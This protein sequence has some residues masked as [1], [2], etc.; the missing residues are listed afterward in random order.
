MSPH[1]LGARR[2]NPDGKKQKILRRVYKNPITGPR[3]FHRTR[4]GRLPPEIREKIFIELLADPPSYAG[5][6][7]L[8]PEPTKSRAAAK[9]FVHIKESWYHVTQTCR[10]IYLESQPIFFAAKAYYLE[11][12]QDLARFLDP[13]NLR[14][15][16]CDTITALCL[17]DLMKEELCFT[18]EQVDDLLTRMNEQLNSDRRPYWESMTRKTFDHEACN[19]VKQ[20]KNLRKVGLCMRV[21]EEMLYLNLIYFLSGMRKGLVEFIDA[22]RW[23]I[24]PQSPEDPWSIQYACFGHGSFL[25]KDDQIIP[26]DRVCIEKEV[27]DIDSRAPGLQE[28]DE[29]YIEAEIQ[30]PVVKKSLKRPVNPYISNIDWDTRSTGSEMS[31]SSH[32]SDE[33]RFEE[34]SS[35]EYEDDWQSETLESDHLLPGI[36]SGAD[37]MDQSSVLDLHDQDGQTIQAAAQ[38]TT[39]IDQQEN[40]D[41]VQATEEEVSGTRPTAQ[42][43]HVIQDSPPAQVTQAPDDLPPITMNDLPLSLDTAHDDD[44]VQTDS[45]MSDQAIQIPDLLPNYEFFGRWNAE[46][47]NSSILVKDG[48]PSKSIYRSSTSKLALLDIS[49]SPSPYTEEEMESY[50]NRSQPG[51]AKQ[52]PRQKVKTSSPSEGTQDQ[53]VKAPIVRKGGLMIMSQHLAELLVRSI[54]TVALFLLF[55]VLVMVPEQLSKAN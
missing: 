33:I 34:V 23:L 22:S 49:D 26:Y 42:D 45:G 10:Q 30:L 20:L 3:P 7:T 51:M 2:G 11:N 25:G 24:R 13:S 43:E 50:E 9:R 29:R 17:K 41:L 31:L 4:F 39:M 16:R 12:T 37:V 35:D 46:E 21:G 18:K 55:L 52:A 36:E 19:H 54:Q 38:A 8:S 28:G 40:Q 6:H 5:R 48:T 53:H 32:D 14:F 44:Q 1:L 47:H 15:L 27:T